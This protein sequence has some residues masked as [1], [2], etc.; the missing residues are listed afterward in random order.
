MPRFANRAIAAKLR[1]AYGARSFALFG[2][3]H[4]RRLVQ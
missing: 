3:C 4:F 2:A 1:K